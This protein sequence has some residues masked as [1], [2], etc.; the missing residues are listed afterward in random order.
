MR[1]LVIGPLSNG[2]CGNSDTLA[3]ET[4]AAFHKVIGHDGGLCPP[5]PPG[6]SA[7]FFQSGWYCLYSDPWP[8]MATKLRIQRCQLFHERLRHLKN[9]FKLICMALKVIIVESK[10]DRPDL[11]RVLVRNQ[12]T[13]AYG[14]MMVRFQLVRYRYGL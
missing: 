10:H 8:K 4:I 3:L 13:F 1:K 6:F 7:V 5:N 9:D 14:M 2:S 11:A 12:M